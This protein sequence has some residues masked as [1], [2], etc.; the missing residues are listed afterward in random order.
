MERGG[1][2]G[3]PTGHLRDRRDR[4][5]RSAAD[6]A[7]REGGQSVRTLI[8]SGAPDTDLERRPR[9]Q[10]R[11][12]KEPWLDEAH[13]AAA[14]ISAIGVVR[15]AIADINDHDECALR[16][17]PVNYG[18]PLVAADGTAELTARSLL[19]RAGARGGPG[20]LKRGIP[21][22]CRAIGVRRCQRVG[23]AP[24]PASWPLPPR[25]R[26]VIPAHTPGRVVQTPLPSPAAAV[27][28]HPRRC[29]AGT[30]ISGSRF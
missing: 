22:H 8:S 20:S 28:S 25:R 14:V 26:A 29:A 30:P 19:R 6:G 7:H 18:A 27:D 17:A 11:W 16:R 4:C 5:C 1:G 2:A 24:Q 23:R 13:L 3:G 10:G 9:P 15:Q 21:A 12:P